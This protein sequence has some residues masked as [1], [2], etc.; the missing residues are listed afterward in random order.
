MVFTGVMERTEFLCFYHDGN[1][2][3]SD[4]G[5]S[6]SET[7]PPHDY[8]HT[9]RRLWSDMECELAEMVCKAIVTFEI[10]AHGGGWNERVY[11]GHIITYQERRLE[12]I[13]AAHLEQYFRT[14]DDIPF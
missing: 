1:W 3:A 11:K 5:L 6:L 9:Q 13:E 8:R 10:H 12:P 4:H 7:Y 14:I 2:W